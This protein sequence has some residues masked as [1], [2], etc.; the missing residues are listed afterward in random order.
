MMSIRS[1]LCN[2]RNLVIAYLSGTLFAIGYWCLIDA[3][4]CNVIWDLTP[5]TKV[6]FLH[7]LPAIAGTIALILLNMIPADSMDLSSFENV[8]ARVKFWLFFCMVL[9]FGSVIGASW[10]LFGQYVAKD[11]DV[12]DKLRELN[13]DGADGKLS[14]KW[15]GIAVF[16]Q[17]ILILI[18]YALDIF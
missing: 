8:S 16:I 17:N 3:T 13:P 18:R 12:S 2:N 9:S 7:W 1:Y 4:A 5:S 14:A 11:V 10:L 15:P 6:V